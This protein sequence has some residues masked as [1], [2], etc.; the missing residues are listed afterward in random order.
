[1]KK[2][3]MYHEYYVWLCVEGCVLLLLSFVAFLSVS[4]Y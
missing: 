4:V 3:K 1:M 2:E